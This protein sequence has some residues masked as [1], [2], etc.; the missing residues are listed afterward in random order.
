MS[1]K[2]EYTNNVIASHNIDNNNSSSSVSS[3]K[4]AITEPLLNVNENESVIDADTKT[5]KAPFSWNLL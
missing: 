4:P 1:N 2:K 3:E 5:L